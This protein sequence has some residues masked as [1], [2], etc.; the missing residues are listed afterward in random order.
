MALPG[1]PVYESGLFEVDYDV[2]TH[3]VTKKEVKIPYSV[4]PKNPLVAKAMEVFDDVAEK[5]LQE[6]KKKM[7]WNEAGKSAP[8]RVIE[9][10]ALTCLPKLLNRDDLTAKYERVL[11]EVL[12][13]KHR[14]NAGMSYDEIAG[15]VEV[16]AV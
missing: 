6:V 3:P 12:S 9:I 4:I 2:W 8:K 14:K 11:N 1:S 15:Q 5:K 16:R 13:G 7:K 10:A